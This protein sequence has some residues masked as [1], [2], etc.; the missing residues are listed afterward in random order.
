MGWRPLTDHCFQGDWNEEAKQT[1][2]RQWKSNAGWHW[3]MLVNLNQR[4]LFPAKIAATT[5][6][7]DIVL[8]SAVVQV[9]HHQAHL[10]MW[11]CSRGG[12]WME[13]TQVG[14]AGSWCWQCGWRT[15]IR[16]VE[17]GFCGFVGKSTTVLLKDMGLQ[18]QALRQT[19]KAL[20]NAAEQANWRLWLMRIKGRGGH[21]RDPHDDPNDACAYNKFIEQIKGLY[22]VVQGSIKIYWGL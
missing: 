17:F 8:W 16:P 15:A 22:K 19:I 9:V 5:H 6:R 10:T 14:R 18:G 3:D 7:P 12:L 4:L 21:N 11:K 13:S 2:V 20:S 1:K